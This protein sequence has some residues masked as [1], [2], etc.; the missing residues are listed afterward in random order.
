MRP[1]L[2]FLALL[3]AALVSAPVSAHEFWL[4]PTAYQVAANGSLEATIVNG[5]NFDGV[6]ISY[7]PQR[8]VRFDV[9]LGDLSA[10]VEARVGNNPALQAPSLGEGLNIVAYQSTNATVTYEDWEKFARFA[11]HKGFVGYQEAHTARGLPLADFKEVYS[12]F[13]KTLIGVGTSAGADQRV[14]LETEFVALDNPYTDDL[15]G[16]MRLQLFYGDAVR[17]NTQ[18]EVFEKP[19]ETAET[20]VLYQTDADGIATITVLP[21]HSYLVNAV[22]L[23]EPSAA[24]ATE[25]DAVWE[26]LWASMT[27]AIPD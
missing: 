19:L 2:M 4:E 16:G 1:A 10:P 11:G 8:F 26:T 22:V 9:T 6:V 18:I 13:V 7:F 12:R 3:S 17:A 14:G 24:L 23:R 20:P 27:F 21:G 25:F 5:Q 15:T